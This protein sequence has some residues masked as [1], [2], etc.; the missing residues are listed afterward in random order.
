MLSHLGSLGPLEHPLGACLAKSDP[1]SQA[2]VLCRW[3]PILMGKYHGPCK[4][5]QQRIQYISCLL[6]PRDKPASTLGRHPDCPPG[7]LHR[8]GG[9]GETQG[10][11]HTDTIRQDTAKYLTVPAEPDPLSEP[12]LR[13]RRPRPGSKLQARTGQMEETQDVMGWKGR[14]VSPSVRGLTGDTDAGMLTDAQSGF[15]VGEGVKGA[16]RCPSPSRVWGWAGGERANSGSTLRSEQP[17]G[18]RP[19]GRVGAAAED[20]GGCIEDRRK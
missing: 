4:Q 16:H 3:H 1:R 7:W 15:G 12:E 8:L 6:H 17:C 13:G 11:A 20:M 18:G 9:R 2:Q 14:Q 10:S 19:S 5:V